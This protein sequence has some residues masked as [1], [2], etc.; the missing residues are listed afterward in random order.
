[1]LRTQQNAGWAWCPALGG[2][3][4][5]FPEQLVVQTATL[6]A[7]RLIARNCLRELSEKS[8]GG[9]FGHHPQ[10]SYA[11]RPTHGRHAEKERGQR[12][13]EKGKRRR[14]KKVLGQFLLIFFFLGFC[15]NKSGS[16]SRLGNSSLNIYIVQISVSHCFASFGAYRMERRDLV[17]GS[18]CKV[19]V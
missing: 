17:T 12:E 1:M 9:G 19:V 3:D 11:C 10:A 6:W 5:G 4:G 7:L 13:R 14:E 15:S 18:K 2:R 8:N 16:N